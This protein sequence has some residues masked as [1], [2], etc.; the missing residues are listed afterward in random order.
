MKTR[1]AGCALANSGRHFLVAVSNAVPMETDARDLVVDRAG[2]AV[3][4]LRWFFGVVV[5]RQTYL[6]LAYLL[7]AFPI[8]LA[9]FV[10]YTVGIAVGLGLAIVLVGVLVLAFM[11]VVAL[12]I[13]SLD[14][15]VTN[16]FLGTAAVGRTLTTGGSRWDQAKSVLVDR[17]TWTA[18][19]YLPV[20][21][22]LGLVAF[23]VVFTG[24]PTAVAMLTVP[25]YYDRAGLYVG[26]VSDRA[27]E[28]HETIYLGWNYVLV[29]IEAAFTLGYWEIDT[30]GAA[31]VV[32]AVGFL[33]LFTILHVCNG[34]AGL[35]ARYAH[36][37]LDGSVDLL[38]TVFGADDTA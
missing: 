27:P 14:R 9:Y 23:G 3:G 18:L 16:R 28:I 4:A 7:L 21:F 2:D 34:L 38:A 19:V 22:V 8:G 24:F 37:S 36:W 20:K 29:G 6:N 26:I 35:W 25:F 17:R 1:P 32:A 33:G 10:L 30:L 12:G 31:V 5:R 11:L 15:R 13:A